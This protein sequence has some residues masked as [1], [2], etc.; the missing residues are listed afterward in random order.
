M[1]NFNE[2]YKQHKPMVLFF[3]TQKLGV[4]EAE[5]LTQDV[6]MKVYNNLHKYDESK[7]KMSTWIMTFAKNAI[8]D[9]YRK[10]KLETTSID[11]FVTE[12]GKELFQIPTF[13]NPESTM[14]DTEKGQS[15]MNHILNLP[16]TYKRIANLY[17]N[18]EMSYNEIASRMNIPMGTVKAQI[19]RARKLLQQSI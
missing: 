19:S 9:R 11:S 16:K 15:V 8:I 7:A 1:Q 18:L 4:V 10:V 6:F 13:S 3:A 14:V 2:I 12:D 5:E 17:F